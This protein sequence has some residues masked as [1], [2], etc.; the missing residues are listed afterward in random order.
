M[1]KSL[2]L[3]NALESRGWTNVTVH[4]ERISSPL[5]MCGYGGGWLANLPDY[6]GE[7]EPLGLNFQEA[8]HHIENSPW[9]HNNHQK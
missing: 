9:L 5:E 2:K 3:K 8:M 6:P 7:V 1:N 4:W